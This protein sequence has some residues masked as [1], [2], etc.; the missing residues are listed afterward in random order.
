VDTHFHCVET[1]LIASLYLA[2]KNANGMPHILRR[3]FI[4]AQRCRRY[5]YRK[6]SQIKFLIPDVDTHFH[7]VE[8][9]LIA[10]LHLA[11]KNANG[12][13]HIL[14][15]EFIPA[16]RCLPEIELPLKMPTA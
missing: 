11:E 16:Q 10:S 14:R 2:E 13:P 6:I 12:M 5:Y 4:P 8:T 9:R 15:R 1:R 7:C 3:E